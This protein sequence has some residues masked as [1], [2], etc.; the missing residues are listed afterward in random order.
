[1]MDGAITSK[2]GRRGMS[3]SKTVCAVVLALFL[4]ACGSG[5]GGFY[6]H[7]NTGNVAGG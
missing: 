2:N 6:R 4:T 1:M 5:G 7:S 3:K